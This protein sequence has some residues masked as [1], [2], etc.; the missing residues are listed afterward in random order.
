MLQKPTIG[1]PKHTPFPSKHES[2]VSDLLFASRLPITSLVMPPS[3]PD[4][5]RHLCFYQAPQVGF[6]QDAD[7]L[8]TGLTN[9]L[10][11][12]AVLDIL[13]GAGQLAAVAVG[14]YYPLSGRAEV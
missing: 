2:P 5:R 6:H 12:L 14:V 4:C 7:T 9:R 10:H 1:T 11:W 8:A 3:Q 13:I